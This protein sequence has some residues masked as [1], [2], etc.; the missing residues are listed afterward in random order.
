MNELE[1]FDVFLA[2]NSQDKPQVR[3]LAKKLRERSLK[4][5]LDE[6]QILAGE[7]FQEAIQKAIPRT[8][9][10]VICISVNGFGRWQVIELHTLISQFVNRNMPVIP[11]LFPGVNQIPDDLLFLRQFNWVSLNSFDDTTAITKLER[12]ITRNQPRFLTEQ[13]PPSPNA[14]E[15]E[16]EPEPEIELKSEVGVDYSHLKKLLSQEK[17]KEADIET[18][19]LMLKV[20]NQEKRGWLNSED[21]KK[22]PCTDLRTIDQ[23]WVKYSNGRFGFSVQ[24]K[25]YLA[26]GAKPDGN[27]PGDEIWYNFCEQ[28]GWRKQGKWMDYNKLT[29]GISAPEGQLPFGLCF[30]FLGLVC[31]G[32]GVLFSRAETCN[33]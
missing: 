25:I 18:R 11:V 17:W 28:V 20:A 3:N 32:F 31:L 13:P 6:E 9:S 19:K 33:L 7:L 4:P 1:E 21:I 23:L 16:P 15:T 29:F 5:W 8:K 26:C 27:Y 22:F 10:A 2:H 14:I 12:G 24:K 30:W